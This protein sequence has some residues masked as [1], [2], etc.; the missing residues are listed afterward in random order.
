MAIIERVLASMPDGQPLTLPRRAG[1]A[2]RPHLSH[3]HAFAADDIAL[4]STAFEGAL[5][6]LRLINRVDPAVSLVAKRTIELA[7]HGE[8]DPILLRDRVL[9]SFSS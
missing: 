1:Y 8:R 2:I 7:F 9:E 5:R 3:A 6:S 4:L